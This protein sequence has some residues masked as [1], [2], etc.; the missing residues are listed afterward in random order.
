MAKEK[1]DFGQAIR[2]V[3]SGKKIA[4]TGWNGKGMYVYYVPAASYPA[5]TEIAIKQWGDGGLVPYNPYL[6]LKGVD[7]NVSTWVPSINDVLAEDWYV[8]VD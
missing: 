6:A 1:I 5:M 8:V 7:N 4:R 2:E 3:K